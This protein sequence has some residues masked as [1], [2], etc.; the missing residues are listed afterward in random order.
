[1]HSSIR[2]LLLFTGAIC[3]LTVLGLVAPMAAAPVHAQDETTTI[4]PLTDPMA[5]FL[6]SR[7]FAKSVGATAEFRKMEWVAHDPVNNKVYWAMSE[8]SKGMSDGEG[9]IDVEENKCGIIYAGDLDAE[10]NVSQITPVIVGGPFNPDAEENQCDVNNIANPD[11][12]MVD[13]AGRLWIGEDTSHHVNNVLW[14]WDGTKLHRFATVPVGGEVTGL[15]FAPDG[16]L[17]FNSQHPSSV[18]LFPYNRGTVGVV[19]GFK[20]TDDFAELATP[21]G[22]DMHRIMTAAGEYQILGRIGEEI[23]FEAT[24]SRFGEIVR[25]DGTAQLICNSPDGNMYLPIDEAGAEGYLYSNYEC[26]PGGVSR[27]YIRNNGT[28]WDVLEGE[29]VDFAGVNGTWTNCGSS[30]TPWNTALTS[31]EFEPLSTVADWR[32]GDLDAMSDYLGA[33]ANPYDHGFLVEMMP[34]DEGDTIGSIVEKRYAMGR[35]SHE[36][37]VVMPDGKTVYHGDDGT[38][39]VFFKFV[40]DEAGDLSTGTLYAAKATQMDDGSFGFEWIELGKGNDDEIA[41]AI[42]TMTLPE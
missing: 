4:L 21:A 33:Q 22:A 19:N 37:S 8:V 12:L 5:P 18:N 39:V 3:L 42:S 30:V 31:E 38:D 26:I 20:A 28:S 32:N 1:M 24:G 36:N 10:Y 9:A 2:K 14:M 41:E 29:N 17:F 34:D 6:E 25:A 27:I 15:H 11:N 13:A 35:F 7:A 40:A 23:P 16:T